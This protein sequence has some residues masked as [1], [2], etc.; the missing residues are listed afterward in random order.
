M[1]PETIT[2]PL[3]QVGEPAVDFNDL[4]AQL[5]VPHERHAISVRRVPGKGNHHRVTLNGKAI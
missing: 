3:Q 4:W 1:K 2:L 5:G